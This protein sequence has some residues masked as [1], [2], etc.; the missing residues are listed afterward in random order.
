ME[1]ESAHA[2][3]SSAVGTG[4]PDISSVRLLGAE[5]STAAVPGRGAR[6]SL[7]VAGKLGEWWR[8]QRTHFS[9][10]IRSYIGRIGPD[11]LCF[12]DFPVFARVGMRFES[13]LGHSRGVFALTCVQ[14][15]VVA[16]L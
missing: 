15:L 11:C 6:Q 1:F 7:C 10:R 12:L 13:H 4:W 3:R 9:L 14:K 8:V 5:H 16:S 2:L